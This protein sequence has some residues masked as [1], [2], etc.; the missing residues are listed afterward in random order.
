MESVLDFDLDLSLSP[1]AYKVQELA[2]VLM[3]QFVDDLAH[4][5]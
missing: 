5:G 2:V 1:K 3:M 4:S